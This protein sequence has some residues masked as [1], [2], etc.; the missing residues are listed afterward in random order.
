VKF[1]E[2]LVTGEEEHLKDIFRNGDIHME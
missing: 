1:V 2:E